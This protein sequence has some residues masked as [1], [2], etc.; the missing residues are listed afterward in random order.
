MPSPRWHHCNHCFNLPIIFI[1]YSLFSHVPYLCVMQSPTPPRA[2]HLLFIAFTGFTLRICVHFM[3]LCYILHIEKQRKPF[4]RCKQADDGWI[5]LEA[6]KDECFW[7]FCKICWL[8]VK[9]DKVFFL[10]LL[11]HPVDSVNGYL[12]CFVALALVKVY[13]PQNS[14][15][16]GCLRHHFKNTQIFSVVIA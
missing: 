6:Q 5:V 2:L 16:K 15:I 10:F 11:K 8:C 3:H 12:Q 7:Q 1:I 14:R 4:N 9:V 13:L